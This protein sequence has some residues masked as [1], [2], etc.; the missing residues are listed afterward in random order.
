MLLK[1][2]NTTVLIFCLYGS[3]FASDI[4]KSDSVQATQQFETGIQHMYSGKFVKAIEYFEG[5]ANYYKQVEDWYR[6]MECN[7]NIIKSL[8][9][10]GQLSRAKE[11]SFNV[12]DESNSIAGSPG[13]FTA[14]AYRLMAA[15]HAMGGNLDSALWAIAMDGEKLNSL[16]NANEFLQE[17]LKTKGALL[18]HIS[19]YDSALRC[20]Q[21]SLELKKQ[22][23]G[24]NHVEVA[25]ITNNIGV[26]YMA[27]NQNE[28]A[29]EYYRKALNI[30]KLIGIEIPGQMSNTFRNIA[31]AYMNMKEFDLAAKNYH[32]ALYFVRNAPVINFEIEAGAMENLG[33]AHIN[34][35]NWDS[36]IYYL[37][38][39]NRIYK[40][41]LGEKSL[42]SARTHGNLG[43]VY[44]D[45][46]AYDL[47]RQELNYSNAIF[48]E[49]YQQSRDLTSLNY[50]NLARIAQRENDLRLALKMV[51]KSIDLNVLDESISDT[52]IYLPKMHQFVNGE[53]L[54]ESLF[55]HGRILE[56]LF[57]KHTEWDYLYAAHQS[58]NTGVHIIQLM[59]ANALTTD[60]QVRLNALTVNLHENVMKVCYNIHQ[61]DNSKGYLDSAYYALQNYKGGVLQKN[62]FRN[63]QKMDVSLPDSIIV[64][65][66]LLKSEYNRL[67]TR[68]V[69]LLN[70][71]NKDSLL[72]SSLENEI[73]ENKRAQEQ[74]DKFLE[75]QYTQYYAANNISTSTSLKHIQKSLSPKTVVL[76]YLMGDSTIHVFMVTRDKMRAYQITLPQKFSEKIQI[77]NSNEN[78]FSTEWAKA[79]HE[80]YDVVLSKIEIP[81]GANHLT[82]I[83]D[84]VLWNL[85]FDLILTE[86]VSS[87]NLKHYPYLLKQ[88][89]ISYGY[90]ANLLLRPDTP[91]ENP[92][93]NI[94]AFSFGEEQVEAPGDIISLD[95]LRDSEE[96]LPGTAVEIAHVAQVQQGDYYYGERASESN[97]KQRAKDYRIL[98]LAVHGEVDNINPDNS[99]LNFYASGD[100]LEDGELYA[101]ELYNMRLNAKMAVLSAC[102]TGSGKIVGGE[103]IMSLGR[104]FNYAG[105]K[106]LLL[107]R[108]EVSDH[109]TPTL[110][111]YF[112]EGLDEGQTKSKALQNAKIRYLAETPDD[113]RLDP[114]YWASFYVLGDDEPITTSNHYLIWVLLA[115]AAV[116]WGILINTRS[117]KNQTG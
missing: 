115:A 56:R 99:R 11:K 42:F 28:L 105:V 21:K 27:M 75:S 2:I 81:E 106:S 85:N 23:S 71:Q 54:L 6:Y 88:F 63:S 93:L 33:N 44:A 22:I 90:A 62:S 83:P 92:P 1:T 95:L 46:G 107:T 35:M 49:K 36:A 4:Q 43:R 12:I 32:T 102:N 26:A 30:R 57:E 82:I 24:E 65:D 77:L 110:M 25:G 117:R 94:M 39:A 68:L 53:Y 13:Q 116:L 40:D 66:K 79:S 103:G 74:I 98:H 84:G 112:Y 34:L 51:N 45:M 78:A 38:N 104:A 29:I 31:T 64:R 91:Q 55:E 19:W 101:F 114:Y 41:A 14:S 70:Q 69:H 60:D 16:N 89:S 52:S 9:R 59:N 97:F 48:H 17:H 73:F 18:V 72:V 8:L 61:L 37:K 76:D 50:I 58:Y 100:T 15:A 108:W 96:I 111:Q 7:N 20:F 87:E 113:V 5:A 109:T 47:A 10:S 86:A 80:L 3:G 67:N